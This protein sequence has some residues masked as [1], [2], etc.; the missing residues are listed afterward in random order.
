MRWSPPEPPPAG[1]GGAPGRTRAV[2]LACTER[3]RVGAGRP[4][5][6]E[7]GRHLRACAP[8]R[9]RLGGPARRARLA[10]TP[11]NLPGRNPGARR[12]WTPQALAGRAVAQVLCPSTSAGDPNGS[13]HAH[14]THEAGVR[15][16]QES[17]SHP[18]SASS[19]PRCRLG[20]LL[21]RGLG[22]L[23][24][25]HRPPVHRGQRRIGGRGGR[26][27]DLACR[28]RPDRAAPGPR[29]LAGRA[30][31]LPGARSPRVHRS[32]HGST[33]GCSRA[34]QQPGE[35]VG[36]AGHGA[37]HPGQAAHG[38][39][40]GHLWLRRG[41]PAYPAGVRSPRRAHRSAERRR[42][43]P[44]AK[45]GLAH[46]LP[47]RALRGV[48]PAGPAP[49]GPG[50]QALSRGSTGRGPRTVRLEPGTLRQHRDRVSRPD[51]PERASLAPGWRLGRHPNKRGAG[52]YR[53]VSQEL[54]TVALAHRSA[55][56]VTARPQLASRVAPRGLQRTGPRCGAAE[57][58]GVSGCAG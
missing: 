17:P 27:P 46:R 53:R 37:P 22:R 5:R 7:R 31:H 20:S 55:A 48:R 52:G 16:A 29:A 30:G 3:S 23:V 51:P 10:Q 21:T 19:R 34:G 4:L 2:A 35:V 33:L 24:G 14:D 43:R 11:S 6:R 18:A 1:A 41:P 36:S 58:R 13:S 56:P 15:L 28:W 57:P 9:P 40:G 54:P 32:W 8:A 39:P 26:G 45:P 44:R 38:R 49:A 25:A 42:E 12:T 50:P 47:G